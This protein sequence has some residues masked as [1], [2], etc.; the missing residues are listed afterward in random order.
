MAAAVEIT[1]AVGNDASVQV[2]VAPNAVSVTCYAA[3][4]TL[5]RTDCA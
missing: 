1:L 3:Q 2:Q 4:S 5:T